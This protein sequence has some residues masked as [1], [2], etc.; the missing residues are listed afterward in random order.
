MARSC[1]PQ[2]QALGACRGFVPDIQ[3]C[4]THGRD[5]LVNVTITLN[6]EEE[7]AGQSNSNWYITAGSQYDY[8]HSQCEE[9]WFINILFNTKV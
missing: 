9:Q 3:V 1:V 6:V 8:D 7:E 4:G 5:D 2:N